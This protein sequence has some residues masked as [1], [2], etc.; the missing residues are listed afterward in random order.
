MSKAVTLLPIV[1]TASL[2][3]AGRHRTATNC[4][5]FTTLPFIDAL[6]ACAMLS[7]TPGHYE[8]EAHVQQRVT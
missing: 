8:E 7:A 4:S 1:T 2:P 3:V 6:N 5:F